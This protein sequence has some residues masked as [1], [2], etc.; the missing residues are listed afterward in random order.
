MT[1]AWGCIGEG[2]EDVVGII[3]LELQVRRK[4]LFVV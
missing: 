1:V 3:R 2:M 4:V